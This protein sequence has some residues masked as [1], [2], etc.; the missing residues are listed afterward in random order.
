VVFFLD[1]RG[2]PVLLKPPPEQELLQHPSHRNVMLARLNRTRKLEKDS[3]EPAKYAAYYFSY[4]RL[5]ELLEQQLVCFCMLFFKKIRDWTRRA[6]QRG[7][8][9]VDHFQEMGSTSR[10]FLLSS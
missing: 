2:S 1:K 6:E 4:N 5:H 3:K 8:L 10:R 7:R 9:R